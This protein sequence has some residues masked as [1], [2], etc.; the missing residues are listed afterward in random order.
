MKKILIILSLSTKNICQINFKS[1]PI[2]IYDYPISSFV[3]DGRY[4]YSLGT[5]KNKKMSFQK[6]FQESKTILTEGALVER[7]KTEFHLEMDC[8]VNHA[9]LIYSNPEILESLY[10]Q[11][12]NIGEKHNL[13]I[14]I[15]TPTRKVNFESLAK[16]NFPNK[17]IISDSC[18][19]LNR[20]REKYKEYSKK[21]MI[22]GL[23][24]CKGDAYSGEKIFS[25]EEANLFH[26]K[27]VEKFQK[28]KI[29]FLFAG[30]MPEINEAIGMS[31]AMSESKIPY[32]I[33]FMI[34]KDGC[35]LDGTVLT[36]A[37]R[38]IDESVNHKPT[39]YMT[40]C[41]HPTNL[42]SALNNDKNRNS[43]QL[44]R[45]SGIQAN[46]SILSPEELINCNTVQQDDFNTIIDQ[47]HLLQK[48]FDLKIL[49]GCCGTNNKFIENL[50]LKI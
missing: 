27:Q 45:F 29:D 33:S 50:S 15:M 19:Y 3:G 35:L 44:K 8:F 7:L 12:L 38:L 20:I 22:G 26:K 17:D 42:I 2:T 36:D 41:I 24:G 9:G 47:M 11:Y 40:N 37:I 21:I 43:P 1:Q 18:S 23:L 4:N 46:A 30:I 34:R 25:V 10:K 5:I 31:Q 14:M 39:C 6:I 28:E 49:G 32:I 16:S 48:N 13:P